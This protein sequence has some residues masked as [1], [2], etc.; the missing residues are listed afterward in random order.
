MSV[1][2]W[3]LLAVVVLMG[4]FQM[5]S[6]CRFT[7]HTQEQFVAT[8]GIYWVLLIGSST[9]LAKMRSKYV[10]QSAAGEHTIYGYCFTLTHKYKEEEV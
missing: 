3:S 4:G 1:L 9:T 2:F 10:V 6:A 8:G 7:R 5:L